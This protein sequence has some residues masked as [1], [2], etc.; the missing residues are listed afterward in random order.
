[1]RLPGRSQN[2]LGQH[3]VH[4]LYAIYDLRDVQIHKSFREIQKLT[5]RIHEH[6]AQNAI[7]IPLWQL[8]TYV[9][10]ADSVRDATLDPRFAASP[11]VTGEPHIR[12]YA[13]APLITAAGYRLGMLCLI[14]RAGRDPL[15]PDQEANL[16]DLAAMVAAE[17]AAMVAS[18]E[19]TCPAAAGAA[20]RLRLA[21]AP[22]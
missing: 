9:A 14:D 1:M 11:L 15:T 16:T 21:A 18:A 4:P 8:D 22:A 2:S 10:V 19:R 13:G 5:H 6:V 12:F 20:T 17:V 3:G 7:V